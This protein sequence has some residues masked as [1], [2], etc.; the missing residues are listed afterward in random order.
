MAAAAAALLLLPP[1][2][3]NL[4]RPP[5]APPVTMLR[6]IDAC[7][8]LIFTR[9]AALDASGAL[10]R[11]AA[12]LF[13]DARAQSTLLAVLEP[14]DRP[15]PDDSPLR[16]LLGAAPLLRLSS[17]AVHTSELTALRRQLNVEAP[18]GFGG[19]DGFGR[20][21]GMAYGR[22]PL[23]ARC[24]VLVTTL[25]ETAAARGAGMRAV[26]L[27]REE[28]GCVD[29][30]LDG[31]ADACLDTLGEEAEVC[32]L[33]VD[34]LSTP[35]AFWLNPPL[36]R[37]LDG[38]AVD[39]E[40]G[41]SSSAGGRG[42]ADLEAVLRDVEPRRGEAG[43]AVSAAEAVDLCRRGGG[44][45]L[46]VRQPAEYRL[47]GHVEGS[48][49][50]AAYSWEHGF[51]LPSP[52]FA[53]QV[54]DEYSTEAP[55]VLVCADGSLSKGAAAVL[56]SAAF[57]EVR[58]LEGGLRAWEADAEDDVGVPPLVVDEDGQAGLTGAWV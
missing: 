52:S 19:S 49:N 53:A 47:D 38:M 39:P 16:R 46:D 54:A 44:T 25:Q 55:L 36:P 32:A 57:T 27:P 30:E 21:P 22:E 7:E 12:R 14:P 15:V 33:R 2:P 31:V 42:A 26:A 23:A 48:A 56:E 45:L 8:A 43:R 1:F 34:D 35:G 13:A 6:N 11:G 17:S 29:E 41:L 28:G 24:V 3:P 4:S 37:D 10:R 40:T 51:Y 20:A 50:I 18:E 58:Y 5:R 9:D